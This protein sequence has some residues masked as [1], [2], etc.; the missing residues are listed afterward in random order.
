[1]TQFIDPSNA[2]AMDHILIRDV[3]TK[4]ILINQRGNKKDAKHNNESQD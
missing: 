1:M 4:E 2:K 3:E